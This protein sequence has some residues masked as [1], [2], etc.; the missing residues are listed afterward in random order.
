[1]DFLRYLL[2]KKEKR[3]IDKA[4]EIKVIEINDTINIIQVG[5]MLISFESNSNYTEAK[6][7]LKNL[8][9]NEIT[10]FR[11]EV[12]QQA[13]KFKTNV[14]QDEKLVNTVD[15]DYNPLE[16]G[17]T[18]KILKNDSKTNVNDNSVISVSK[19]LYKWDGVKFI[20]GSGIKYHH[21]DYT[22]YKGY[23][24]EDFHINGNKLT[25]H[26]INKYDS[27]TIAAAAPIVAGGIVGYL[28]G[29]VPSG[30]AGGLL[31]TFLTGK[32]SKALLDEQD[33]VWYWNSY[34][35]SPVYI[36]GMV[37]KVPLYFRISAYTLW[38]FLGISNP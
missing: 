16:T 20:K 32:S 30:I 13:G 7:E 38:N 15:S 18:S 12:S 37:R 9:T 26:H 25:H 23:N 6:M 21:P 29:E 4:P 14:Y 36:S 19:T 1:M 11:Y 31:G 24:Y 35:W 34:T 8:K 2:I 22:T 5:D 28:V 3:G 33:C 27:A 17:A 10:N